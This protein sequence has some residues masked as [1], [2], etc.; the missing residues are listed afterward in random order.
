MSFNDFIK[1]S[2]SN[3]PENSFRRIAD[4]LERIADS[5]ERLS[6]KKDN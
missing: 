2:A 5:L 3:S 1:Q 6:E 4:A